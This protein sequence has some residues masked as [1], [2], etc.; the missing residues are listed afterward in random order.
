MPNPPVN[1]LFQSGTTI[2]SAWLNGV[3][4]FVNG[5]L[6]SLPAGRVV[7]NIA[8]LKTVSKLLCT[9]VFVT[10]YYTSGDGGGGAYYLDA[11]DSTSSD[12]GGTIIVASDGGRWKLSTTSTITVRQFG[13]KGDGTTDD[14]PAINAAFT[15]VTSKLRFPAGKYKCNST[16]TVANSFGLT[17]EGDGASIQTP[18]TTYTNNAVLI[19]DGAP[20]GS[21]GLYFNV[22]VG[23]TIRNLV[24]S[25]R[26]GG[27]GG[28]T[29]LYMRSGHDFR[30]ENIVV[31]TNVG[32]SGA[33]IVLGDGSG[34]GSTFQGTIMSCKVIS[35]AE[36]TFVSNPTNTSLTFDSCYGIGGTYQLN[37][38]IYSTLNSCASDA[39]ALYGYTI[40]NCQ[41]ITFNSAGAES[42]GRGH[43]YISTSSSNLVFNAPVG[44]NNNTAAITNNGALFHIDG[45][46]GA[47]FGITINN[48]TSLTP[49]AATTADIYATAGTGRVTINDV[50][51]AKL[52]KG[53]AGDSTWL[54]TKL[55]MSGDIAARSFTP[56]QGTG[57]TFTGTPVF[58][59]TF[60]RYGNRITFNIDITGYTNVSVA[61]SARI[62]LPFTSPTNGQ[63]QA[64]DDNA[65]S[66]GSCLITSAGVI[67]VPIISSRSVPLH[68][69]GQII[70]TD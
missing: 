22:F 55:I 60:V 33:G 54:N 26:R 53:V 41:G 7:S 23:A 34:A 9:S 51:G 68:F 1:T 10:G 44:A 62:N 8:T 20:S 66:L 19:F 25:Q 65:N 57:W 64:F 2:T 32:G 35:Q 29:A 17:V 42:C 14:A 40:S 6:Q 13:A 38:T 43:T 58:S 48:P 52:S 5:Q 63:A 50:T 56:T 30:L 21:N 45:S 15:A 49:N 37:G 31:D 59:G 39:G 28:G 24:I 27:T 4:D 61:S 70:T 46:A 16:I 18:G 11:N 3:N 69:V 67:F 36:A 47:C 12:N